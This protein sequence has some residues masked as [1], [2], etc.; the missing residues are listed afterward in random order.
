M[1]GPAYSDTPPDETA[2]GDGEKPAIT[3]PAVVEKVIKPL[4]PQEP[5]KAQITIID[6]A[7]DL[8]KEIRVEN[9]LENAA[10]EKVKLKTGA[11][12]E[13]TIEAPPDAVEKKKT[14]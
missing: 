7:D 5:E 1:S 14:A 9:S 12:V 3:L 13:V 2:N 10:G 8:Y 4:D 11:E 6:G